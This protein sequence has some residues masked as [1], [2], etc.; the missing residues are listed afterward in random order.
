MKL[1]TVTCGSVPRD[2][3]LNPYQYIYCVVLLYLC[4]CILAFVYLCICICV[5]VYLHLCI[6]VFVFLLLSVGRCHIRLD[7]HSGATL[8]YI[9]SS[10]T[11]V[12]PLLYINSPHPTSNLVTTQPGLYFRFY[13]ARLLIWWRLKVIFNKKKRELEQEIVLCTRKNFP[14]REGKFSMFFLFFLFLWFRIFQK[15]TAN[16]ILWRWVWTRSCGWQ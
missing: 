12:A 9:T 1:H 7:Y 8:H 5:A 2:Q 15:I 16:N 4:I 6:C 13:K 14:K 11:S 10:V 3:Q